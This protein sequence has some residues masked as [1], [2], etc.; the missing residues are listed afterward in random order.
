MAGRYLLDTS[1]IIPL[2]A[3]DPA[4]RECMAA[5]EQVFISSIA[6]GELCY[7]ARRS[8]KSQQNL[9]S[10]AGLVAQSPVLGCDTGT[11]FLYGEIKNELRV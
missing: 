6:V 1:V 9:E 2:F 4:I 10:I 7:G 11:A 3:S 8:A 5:A